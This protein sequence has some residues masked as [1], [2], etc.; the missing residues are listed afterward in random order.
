M[1]KESRSLK[2]Q[3]EEKTR[4]ANYEARSRELLAQGYSQSV[5]TISIAKANVMAFV[6]AGPFVVAVFFL[7]LFIW[8]GME[9]SFNFLS[10]LGFLGGMIISIPVH[11]FI[12]GLTWHFFCKGGWKSIYFGVM[13][14]T[15][16]PYCHC[17]E[18]LS[19]KSYIAGG[20]MPFLI[21]GLGLSF[22]AV[23]LG[24]PLVLCLGMF[25]IL[26]AGGDT[27]ICLMLRKHSHSLILDHPKDCGFVAFS[28]AQD[29]AQ[30]RTLEK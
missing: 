6:T 14:D 21:L 17:K 12:H 19:L 1:S 8:D 30:S 18:A 4:M 25:N 27:T 11:E 3:E 5:G 22:L 15:L 13:W 9:F 23:A 7:Y 2:R 24:S 16:T 26:A 28:P 10:F 20:I 29:S